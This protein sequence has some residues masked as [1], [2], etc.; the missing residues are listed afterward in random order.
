MKCKFC[1]AELEVGVTRCPACGKDVAGPVERKDKSKAWKKALAIAGVVLL[2]IVLVGAILHFMGYGKYVVHYMKFWRA[3]DLN[4]KLSYTASNN[5]AERKKDIVVATIGDQVLTNGELQVY[6]WF[7]VYD[8]MGMY[9]E[10]LPYMGLD[11]SKPFHEQVVDEKTGQSFQHMFLETALENWTR[12][13]TLVELS[14]E[15]GFTLGEEQQNHVDSVRTQVEELAKEYK[16]TDVEEFIDKEFFPG[17]SLDIYLKY[18]EM[19]YQAIA[20]FNTL[21][22]TMIPTQDQL[23]AYYA[24]HEAEFKEKK[25]DKSAGNYYDVRHIL[26]EVPADTTDSGAG[27]EYTDAEWEACL[28]AAQ[29]LLD[30]FL[31]GEATEEEFAKL[32][33]EHSKDPG[34]AANGGLYD[35]LTKDTGFIKGFTDWYVDESRKPGDTG[36]VKNTESSTQGYHIMYF[37]KSYPVWQEEAKSALVKESMDKALAEGNVKWPAQINYKKIILGQMDLAG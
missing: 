24:A 18:T 12:Y 29:E 8:F 31:A 28:K 22:D 30:Q 27:V 25:I 6:Y 33:K 3:N 34:S 16:Y 17:C 15:A 23:D 14:K 19:S 35:H 32:A 4:Y 21:Y 37:S 26:V 5:A 1:D 11:V 9:G 7:A 36:L 20:Y 2:A 10:Y 13:A